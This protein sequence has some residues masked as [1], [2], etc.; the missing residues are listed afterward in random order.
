MKLQNYY[1]SKGD[2][3]NSNISA[4]RYIK[5][6]VA[7]IQYYGNQGRDLISKLLYDNDD[8]VRLMTASFLL[9]YKTK[10]SIKVLTELSKGTGILSFDANEALKRWKEGNWDLDPLDPNNKLIELVKE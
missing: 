6:Y 3:K 7:L 4:H 8:G 10:E 2:P 1:I 5:D 9:R